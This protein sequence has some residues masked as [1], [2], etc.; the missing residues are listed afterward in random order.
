MASS[1][2]SPVVGRAPRRPAQQ[3]G[4]AFDTAVGSVAVAADL[5]GSGH[6]PWRYQ[7]PWMCCGHLWGATLVPGAARR[8][9]QGPPQRR[10]CDTGSS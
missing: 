6:A 1:A 9:Q 10:C 5:G 4:G 8:P 7:M 3:P 2:D